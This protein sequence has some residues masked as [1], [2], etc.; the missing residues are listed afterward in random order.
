VFLQIKVKQRTK[1]I[2][3]EGCQLAFSALTLLLR[4][5][6]GCLPENSTFRVVHPYFTYA[7]YVMTVGYSISV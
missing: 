4:Y 1:V 2:F 3:T 7:A 6:E 5:Q